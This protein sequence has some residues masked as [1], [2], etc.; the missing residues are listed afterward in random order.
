MLH[1]KVDL[2]ACL[3][4]TTAVCFLTFLVTVRTSRYFRLELNEDPLISSDKSHQPK[5]GELEGLFLST[6]YPLAFPK[7]KS[8]CGSSFMSSTPNL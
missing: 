2:P 6:V 7:L 1:T 5:A 3:R 8:Y 4:L